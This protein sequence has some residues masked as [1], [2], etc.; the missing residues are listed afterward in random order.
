MSWDSHRDAV[1]IR[2]ALL[3]I[4]GTPVRPGVL[5]DLVRHGNEHALDLYLLLRIPLSAPP[6]QLEVN[7]D[8]WAPLAGRTSQSRR[9]ARLAMYRS[10]DRLE[11]LALIRRETRGSR[12]RVELLDESGNGDPY[13]HPA[14]RDERYI[15]LPHSYWTLGFDRKLKLPGKTVLL[16]SLSLS[17]K[18]F[19]LPLAHSTDWYG[20]SA[21]SL[22][23]GMDELVRARL[24]RYQTTEVPAT[25]TPDGITAL[26]RTYLLAG[27]MDR[28][29][30]DAATAH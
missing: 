23:R 24:V 13:V 11:S 10:L 17:P 4:R 19:T 7:A 29:Y 15:K 14:R 9:N 21:P 18:G 8:Y 30:A 22:K 16:L 6:F 25:N 1:P 20:I 3:Q 28:H 2:E 26:R 12:S 27:P 5:A